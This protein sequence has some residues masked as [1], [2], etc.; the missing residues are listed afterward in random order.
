MCTTA[1]VYQDISIFSCSIFQFV[2]RFSHSDCF[3]VFTKWQALYYS[4]K[5]S[6]ESFVE[7]LPDW[8]C[9]LCLK[10]NAFRAI[11]AFSNLFAHA[12]A[13]ISVRG[14]FQLEPDPESGARDQMEGVLGITSA[15]SHVFN[16]L[17]RSFYWAGL[18]ADVV[19]CSRAF[20]L[21]DAFPCQRT[22]TCCS[23]PVFA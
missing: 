21:L 6:N 14:M 15:C 5:E 8:L 7:H 12:S 13:A 23:I 9:L 11:G 20:G 4:H 22:D 2:P 10:P 18:L 1:L 17:P 19:W 3:T 16:R